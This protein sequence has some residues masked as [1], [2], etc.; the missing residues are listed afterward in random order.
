MPISKD[1]KTDRVLIAMALEDQFL[2]I[3]SLVE[4]RQKQDKPYR[5][6]QYLEHDTHI[7]VSRSHIDEFVSDDLLCPVADAVHATDPAKLIPALQL[8]R[9]ALRLSHLLDGGIH[10]IKSRCVGVVQVLGQ[11]ALQQH[12]V[13]CALPMRL[14]IL[15]PALPSN[16]DL[17]PRLW[18]HDQIRDQI[19]FNLRIRSAVLFKTGLH[20]PN[21][22]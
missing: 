21:L 11:R 13:I 19:P 14:K 7:V 15:L 3:L 8:L 10:K 18:V 17:A 22:P 4:I 12:G 1:Q 9:D 16:T 6:Q 2:N 20:F 5:C